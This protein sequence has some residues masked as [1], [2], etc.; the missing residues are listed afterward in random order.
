MSARCVAALWPLTRPSLVGDNEATVS[1]CVRGGQ[2]R[3]DTQLA[4]SMRGRQEA[5]ALRCAGR[6]YTE[7]QLAQGGATGKRQFGASVELSE[8]ELQ[9]EGQ[10]VQR[11]S[12]LTVPVT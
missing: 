2:Q 5:A 6:L 8:D 9:V 12:W 11:A 1:L 3:G 7:G 4:A 10:K